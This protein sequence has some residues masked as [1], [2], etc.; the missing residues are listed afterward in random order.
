MLATE[1]WCQLSCSDKISIHHTKR[2]GTPICQN[3]KKTNGDSGKDRQHQKFQIALLV[4]LYVSHINS[5]LDI[6]MVLYTVFTDWVSR[7]RYVLKIKCAKSVFDGIRAPYRYFSVFFQ[8]KWWLWMKCQFTK[9][10]I[11]PWM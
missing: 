9:T 3:L 6:T 7:I 8:T 1:K 11:K 4:K 10:Y 5:T 2:K